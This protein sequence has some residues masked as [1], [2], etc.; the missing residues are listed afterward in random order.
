[1]TVCVVVTERT[2]KSVDLIVD[3]VVD[4]TDLCVSV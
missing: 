4:G 1:M 3:I 2:F